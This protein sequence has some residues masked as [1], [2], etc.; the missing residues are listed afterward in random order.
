MMR[1]LAVVGVTGEIASS[2]LDL[3]ASDGTF[4]KYVLYGRDK[5]KLNAAADGLNSCAVFFDMAKQCSVDQLIPVG[6]IDGAEEL[7]LLMLAFTIQPL[8]RI[9]NFEEE[10][11]KE[12][13]YTNVISQVCL[14]NAFC[15]YSK[16]RSIPLRIIFIDSGAAYQPICG[17][18]LYCSAKAYMSMYLKCL[19]KEQTA[20]VVL[21]EPGVIDTPM[22]KAIR[23]TSEDIFDDVHV[24]RGYKEKGTLRSPKEVAEQLFA[25]YLSCW[26]AQSL[27]ER[28]D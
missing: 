7:V 4:D 22:Q 28:F 8:E 20:S 9:G 5:D 1:C 11:I 16:Q 15:D 6:E 26:S 19:E 2:I 12:N 24:F 13:I 3:C 25:R 23:E 17:W 10:Q 27:Q 18:S 14:I 21:F